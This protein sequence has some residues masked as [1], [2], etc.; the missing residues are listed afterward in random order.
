MSDQQ[1]NPDSALDAIMAPIKAMPPREQLAFWRRFRI[2]HRRRI[3]RGEA[4]LCPDI[5]RSVDDII[6]TLKPLAAGEN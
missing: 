6:A 1:T 5:L 2:V 3:A 4:M